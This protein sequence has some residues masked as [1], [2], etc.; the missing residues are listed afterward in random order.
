MFFLRW[1]LKT[2]RD[3][4][5]RRTRIPCTWARAGLQRNADSSNPDVLDANM[6]QQGRFLDFHAIFTEG[7]HRPHRISMRIAIPVAVAAKNR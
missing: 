2:V 7:P 3:D 6:G 1:S 4:E 5:N